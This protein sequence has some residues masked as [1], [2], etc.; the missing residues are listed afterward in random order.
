M[1]SPPGAGLSLNWGTGG[2]P[3]TRSQIG[4]ATDRALQ[5]LGLNR[6]RPL[7]CGN[8]L[9]VPALSGQT[10]GCPDTFSDAPVALLLP[11]ETFLLTD[12]GRHRRQQPEE[13]SVRTLPYASTVI[14][15]TRYRYNITGTAYRY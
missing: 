9:Q 8:L 7:P 2:E 15:S 3:R 5:T 13:Y 6:D 4:F 1:P 11:R 10:Q 14:D 12:W